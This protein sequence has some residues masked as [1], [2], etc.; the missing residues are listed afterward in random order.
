MKFKIILY[1]VVSAF[2]KK[3]LLSTEKSKIE[4]RTF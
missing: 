1:I 3:E 2:L 4:K